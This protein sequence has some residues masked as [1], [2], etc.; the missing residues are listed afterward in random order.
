[1]LAGADFSRGTAGTGSWCDRLADDRRD[2]EPVKPEDKA[3]CGG[4]VHGVPLFNLLGMTR[5]EIEKTLA[6]MSTEGLL[7]PLHAQLREA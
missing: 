7:L 4:A 1:M 6:E 5:G 2:Q 3:V